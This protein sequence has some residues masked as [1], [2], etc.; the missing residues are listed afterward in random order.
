MH[1]LGM[2]EL[3]VAGHCLSMGD[4]NEYLTKCWQSFLILTQI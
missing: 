4:W 1:I 2:P 3:D